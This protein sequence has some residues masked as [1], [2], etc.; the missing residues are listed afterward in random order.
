MTAWNARSR[1]VVLP[2][3]LSKLYKKTEPVDPAISVSEHRATIPY[4][5]RVRTNAKGKRSVE[6]F[7]GL[8]NQQ[9][10]KKKQQEGSNKKTST[11]NGKGKK[12]GGPRM[13]TAA[14]LSDEQIQMER[15]TCPFYFLPFHGQNYNTE[16]D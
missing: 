2:A 10:S 16:E 15:L 7:H 1:G 3:T 14:Q 11:T 8:M 13:G 4:V 5:R 12:A 9:N 6:A